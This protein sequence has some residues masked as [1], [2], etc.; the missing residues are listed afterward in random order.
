MTPAAPP[1]SSSDDDIPPDPPPPEPPPAIL[2]WPS[3]A[4]HWMNGPRARERQ[5]LSSITAPIPVRDSDDLGRKND[6]TDLLLKRWIS[7][8][9]MRWMRWQ[10]FA[11]NAFF[12]AYAISKRFDV[13][14]V[15]ISI[16]F[17][18]TVVQLVG[19]VFIIARY[20]FPSGTQG[21]QPRAAR[22]SRESAKES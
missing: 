8:R 3:R 14:P 16:W 4:W 9:V 13:P 19:V 21:G 15:V 12:I 6:E 17:S 11:V 20:L 7:V 1:P 5:L 10:L 2:G 18:A 22:E